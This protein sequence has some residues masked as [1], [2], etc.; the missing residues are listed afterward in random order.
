MEKP[1]SKY[2]NT[3]INILHFNPEPIQN[4]IHPFFKESESLSGSFRNLGKSQPPVWYSQEGHPAL[5]YFIFS[6]TLDR[7]FHYSRFA[8]KENEAQRTVVTSRDDVNWI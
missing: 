1:I 5:S 8:D 6:A 2:Q 7:R 3:K 4:G